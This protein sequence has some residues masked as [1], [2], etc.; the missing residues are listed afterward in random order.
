MF[1]TKFTALA[2]LALA[3][4]AGVQVQAAPMVDGTALTARASST[5]HFVIYQDK[6]LTQGPP[7][8]EDVKGFDTVILSFWLSS[9]MAD[10]AMAW[11]ELTD[12]QRKTMLAK[13]KAAGIKVRAHDA[14][15]T[16]KKLMRGA[17]PCLRFR[18]YRDADELRRGCD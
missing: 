16:A 13:Y 7:N 5:G 4:F 18:F 15:M 9:G 8:V 10:Q 17:A 14:P 1:S 6:W 3:A 12:D 11:Q 2:A